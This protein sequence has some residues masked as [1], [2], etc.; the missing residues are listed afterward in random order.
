[1]KNTMKKLLSLVLCLALL[2][3][4][5]AAVGAENVED[6]V[7]V[8]DNYVYYGTYIVED[9]TQEY[10]LSEL[11]DYTVFALAPSA[12]GKYTISVAD[13]LVGIVSN[14]GMWV[15]VQPSETT[16]TE[17]EVEWECTGVG[18]EIWIAVKGGA[19]TVSVTVSKGDSDIKVIE[20]IPYV[21]KTTPEAF[22]FTGDAA[23]L[24]SV[25]TLNS[26]VDTAVLGEDGYYHLNSAD[27][28]IL[29]ANLEDSNM[30]LYAASTYGQL[31]GAVYD[32]NGE[33]V[34][35]TDYNEAFLE[36]H[37]CADA[38]T[39]LYPLTD[40]LIEMFR[41]IGNN[42]GW[43]GAEGWIGGTKDDAWMF[44]CYYTTAPLPPSYTVGDINNDGQVNGI[45]S[46]TLM[47]IVAGNTIVEAGSA[48]A[49]AADI[50]GD[51]DINAIDTNMLKR[52]L[53]G[54]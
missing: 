12:T 13:T 45:D 42:L 4:S 31:K 52:K 24:L 2:S 53:A 10:A 21:N 44:A 50:N 17:A 34:S 14:N 48:S 20:K 47:R 26:T 3:F 33:L 35:I 41:E 11:Y 38:A 54:A 43:Y 18:Q 7:D 23:E 39:K 9:G 15:T 1:M 49:L 40:D 36:Y 28:Y 30:N 37:A 22:T 19:A 5:I 6:A 51:G 27:G 16:V 25:N 29:F 32:E 8:G 46:N